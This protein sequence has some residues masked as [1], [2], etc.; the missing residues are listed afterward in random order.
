MFHTQR[1]DWRCSLLGRANA[2]GN[3]IDPNNKMTGLAS[4]ESSKPKAEN[5]TANRT[6]EPRL[7]LC[8]PER[9]VDTR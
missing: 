3:D 6:E 4:L 8:P 2:H 9:V 5:L 1:V 7:T